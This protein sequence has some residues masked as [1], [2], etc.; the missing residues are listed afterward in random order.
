MKTYYFKR[1]ATLIMV[2]RKLIYHNSVIIDI[3][4]KKT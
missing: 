2:I 3:I 4:L 1:N